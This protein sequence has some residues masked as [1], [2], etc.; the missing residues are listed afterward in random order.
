MNLKNESKKGFHNHNITELNQRKLI[1]LIPFQLLKFR[2]IISQRP[3]KEHFHQLQQL[4]EHDIMESIEANMKVGN[5]THDDANQLLEL[6][7]Q[8]YQHVY[9][10]YEE[11]GG[12]D[13]M[14]PLLNG[15]LELPMDKYRIRI[16]E[17]EEEIEGAKKET[18]EV[19]KEAEEVKKEAEEVKKEAESVKKEA[20]AVKKEAE[21]VKKEA[22]AVKKENEAAKKRIQELEAALQSRKTT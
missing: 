7:G 21:A 16:D 6:T 1:V 18:E 13:D 14:K 11:L 9:A 12:L 22:E 2:K 17:L 10:H 19:K 20:E 15:A 5:I 3:T 8:L 4:V